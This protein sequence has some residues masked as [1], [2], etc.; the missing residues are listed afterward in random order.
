MLAVAL[1]VLRPDPPPLEPAVL[2][3]HL[4]V[5][6]SLPLMA[7]LLSLGRHMPDA[8]PRLSETQ[9]RVAAQYPCADAQY[10]VPNTWNL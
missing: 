9:V 2:E 4:L 6:L 1:P 10:S 5:P 3:R 8:E 7:G